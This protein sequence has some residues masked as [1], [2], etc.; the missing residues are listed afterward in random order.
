MLSLLTFRLLT[1]VIHELGHAIP[2]LLLTNEKVTVYMGSWGNPEKSLQFQFG[3][4][5]YF[6]K[7]NLFYWKGGLCVPHEKNISLRN[8]FIITIFGPLLSLIVSGIGV[9]AL[10]LYDFGDIWNLVIFALVF[11]C[12]LDFW[13]NIVP[14][15]DNITLYN[16]NVVYNDGN[17]LLL[18]L[19]LRK[20]QDIPNKAVIHYQNKEYNAAAKLFEKCISVLPNQQ[21]WYR[22]AISSFLKE[23]QTEK[24]TK[25]QD[26]YTKKFI[27]IFN[28]NDFLHLAN[29]EIY[30]GNFRKAL[31]AYQ[32][33]YRINPKNSY[34]LNSLG[35]TLG[36]LGEHEKAIIKLNKAYELLCT[37][38]RDD[39]DVQLAYFYCNRGYSKLELEQ[40]EEGFTD[41]EKA[42]EFDP[43]YAY[44]YRNFG[45]YYFYTNAYQK[46][47]EFY[48][49]AAKMDPEIP[50]IQELIVDN[51]L[52]LKN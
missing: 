28:E 40:L 13:H 43:S 30:N 21:E 27:E 46:A 12:V 14:S 4:L 10:L 41:T 5:E 42:V 44:A 39:M 3:R 23:K 51:L 48:Q 38:E 6:F 8:N 49:K 36:I 47:D 29:V 34:T 7:F 16:G 32:K 19:K 1:T 37:E 33:A 11:S 26:A 31:E 2:A 17:Q 18:L 22:F 24:A 20:I 45:L 25:L 52:K 15:N 35:F 50:F 9:T